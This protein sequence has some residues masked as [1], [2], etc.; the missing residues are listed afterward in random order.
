MN[1]LTRLFAIAALL[2][3][4]SAFAT[5]DPTYTAVREARPDGRTIALT[6]FTF[7]RDVY[8][9]TLN[10]TLYL[11]APADGKTFGAVFLGHGSYE[12]KPATDLE[13]KTLALY[14]GEDKLTTLADT[15]DRATIF[16]ADL[17]QAAEARSAAKAGAPSPDAVNAYEAYLKKQRKDLRT[18]LHVRVVQELING[19]APVFLMWVDGRKYLPALA[20][21]DPLGAE[22]SGIDLISGGEQTMFYVNDPT[23][24]G[25]WY[26]S[27]LKSEIDKGE[28]ATLLPLADARR[29]SI[30][31]SFD[32]SL[33]GRNGISGTTSMTF[34][35][36][37]PGIRL[38]PIHL[39]GHLRLSEVSY[40]AAGDP[41]AWTPLAFIQEKENEDADAAIVFPSALEAGKQYI[42]KFVYKGRE[43]LVDA[44]D[45]NFSI[46]ARTSWYPNVG[47]FSDLAMYDMTFRTSPKLEVVASG[48]RLADTTEGS[49]RISMWKTDHPQRV[50]GFN[51]G[52]FER[53]SMT[54]QD[55]GMSVDV[56][57]S[58][59][60]P[61]AVRD[62]VNAKNLTP[63]DGF[64]PRA[65]TIDTASLAQAALADGVNTARTA[66]A[67][68]GPVADKRISITQQSEWDFG[69]SWPQLIYMPY[70]AFVDST[71]RM[72]MGLA[73][74]SDFVDQVGAHEFGH[75]WWGHSVG[76]KSYHDQ[77]LS[78]GFAEFTSA[79]V[80][81]QAG[82]WAKYNNFWENRRR[83]ILERP[84]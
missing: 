63:S 81:Q 62:M 34:V 75:Q 82:G 79:L 51:Y 32:P 57:T 17:I 49:Q 10:G 71:T 78:E 46:G 53:M 24:G 41:T 40:T 7:D 58:P 30:D 19:G 15:F 18:N 60:T 42:V 9:L 64:G 20:V 80:I 55:S 67:F 35:S 14:T 47:T 70:L 28:S 74:A 76:W 33:F 37:V 73:R 1:R 45:G 72:K 48:S 25:I 36:Q 83:H 16:S 59:G 8:H 39:T 13:R 50:A 12:L 52:H 68:F 66:S 4:S 6:N 5:T 61:A 77:W 69:Q 2:V 38:L 54:D 44:G 22:M 56:Y 3:V 65:V 84:A 31:S 29:Y 23:R 43:V 27:H 26:S 21:V 11:L